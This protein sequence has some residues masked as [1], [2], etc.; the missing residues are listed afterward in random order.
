MF[1][2]QAQEEYWAKS[3]NTLSSTSFNPSRSHV[4][5]DK[6]GYR[7]SGRWDF[8]SGVDSADWMLVVGNAPDG[9]AMLM[10]PKTDYV[11]E[12]TWFVS[13]LRGTGSKDVRMY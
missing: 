13:G 3:H 4:V 7:V 9:P 8:A 11:V 12:D 2:R 6:G 5:S 1:P 10:V